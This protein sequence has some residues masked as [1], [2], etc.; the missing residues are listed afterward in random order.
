[1]CTTIIVTPGAAADGSMFVTHSDDNDLGDERLIRVPAADH[2]EKMRLVYPV[3]SQYPRYVGTALGPAYDTPGFNP[4]EPVGAIPQVSHTHAYYEGDYGIMNEHQLC[5]GECTDAAQKYE[6]KNPDPDHLF[7][8]TQLTRVALE[9][10]TTAREAVEKMGELIDAYGYYGTGETLPVGDPTDAWVFEMCA[11]P[12]IAPNGATLNGKGLWVAKQVPD[13]EVFVAANGFR[14]REI[15][16]DRHGKD[17]LYSPN[18]FSETELLGWWNPGDGKLDWARTVSNGEYNHPYYVLRRVWSVLNRVN[19]SLALPPYVE[20]YFAEKYPFSIKPEKKMTLEDVMG[21]HRDCYEGTE[22]DMTKGMA[23]GPFGNPNRYYNYDYDCDSEDF[24]DIDHQFNRG[25]FERPVSVYYCGYVYVCQARATLPDEVGGVLW[26]GFDQPLTT[27]F[28]PFYAG[29]RGLP[30]SYEYGSTDTF[31]HDFAFWK[32]NAV[33]NLACLK[34]G[35]M[36]KDIKDRRRELENEA[37]GMQNEI[38][39]NAVHLIE[40][41]EIEEAREYLTRIGKELAGHVEAEWWKLLFELF[42]KYSDGFINVKRV[43][44]EDGAVVNDPRSVGYP[45]WWRQRVGYDAGPMHYAP[46]E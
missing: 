42:H 22:F 8:S 20:D 32:F 17:I 26:F 15:D 45:L 41:N 38:E 31:D 39:T 40:G 2:T 1:M 21:L 14:I 19:P 44:K 37:I 5:F 46:P 6:R 25:A 23:A 12:D 4:T 10:C 36:I 43:R 27:C 24:S 11:V 16:P 18:L 30:K 13:G 9:Q 28:T 3:Y 29:A 34:Y 33:S 35:Y 7:Y